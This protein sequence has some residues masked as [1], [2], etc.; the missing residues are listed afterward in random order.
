[1]QED[2]LASDLSKVE[3]YN[4]NLLAGGEF[5]KAESKDFNKFWNQEVKEYIKERQKAC[6]RLRFCKD[7]D[8]RKSLLELIN[9]I[10]S[11]LRKLLL[12]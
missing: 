4:K 12:I 3:E 5:W 11:I 8:E 10:N 7:E 9:H 6:E 2:S 1:M